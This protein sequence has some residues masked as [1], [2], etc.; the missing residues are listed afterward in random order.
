MN[1]RNVT[2]IH[3]PRYV[4]EGKCSDDNYLMMEEGGGAAGDNITWGTGTTE[5]KIER[6]LI[7]LKIIL[8]DLEENVEKIKDRYAQL[9]N[10]T[11]LV[12]SD[13]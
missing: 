9:C 5:D 1:S 13:L 2:N 11:N 4:N 7:S 10:L 8:R 3:H 12:I 6:T